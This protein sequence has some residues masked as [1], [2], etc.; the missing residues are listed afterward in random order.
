MDILE[1]ALLALVG[2][3][4]LSIAAFVASLLAM[5]AGDAFAKVRFAMAAS[6]TRSGLS[7]RH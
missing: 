4:T 7:R 3:W 1:W 5:V 6:I 2:F